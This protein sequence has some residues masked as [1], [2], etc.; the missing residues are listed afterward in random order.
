MMNHNLKIR[1]YKN[2]DWEDISELLIS[3]LFKTKERLLTFWKWQIEENPYVK[4]P[5]T[6]RI[7]AEDVDKNKAVAF[8]AYYRNKIIIKNKE[9][10]A[11]SA[12]HYASDDDYRGVGIALWI[13][14]I[15]DNELCLTNLTNDERNVNKIKMKI[16]NGHIDMNY[17]YFYRYKLK[18][19]FNRKLLRYIYKN[20]YHIINIFMSFRNK[21]T[22]K[23][24]IEKINAFEKDINL[25]FSEYHKYY[26]IFF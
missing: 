18:R 2:S 1:Y 13:R 14:F 20:S 23:I 26:K 5:N 25:I 24:N 16:M 3:K 10:D 21:N 15:R 6:H 22:E 11:V 19:L 12:M 8:L 4:D 7:V 17:S 9:Y